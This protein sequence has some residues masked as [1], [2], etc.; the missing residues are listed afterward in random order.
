[1]GL[2]DIFKGK[3]PAEPQKA[4]PPLPPPI[5]AQQGP[6]AAVRWVESMGDPGD[7]PITTLSMVADPSDRPTWDALWKA[8]YA[9]PAWH[10]ITYKSQE[11]DSQPV[12]S[13]MGGLSH[14]LIYTSATRAATARAH[15]ANTI[16]GKVFEVL[17]LPVS[18]A[19]EYVCS[20]RKGGPVSVYFNQGTGGNG[21][22][23]SI[24]AVA[25]MLEYFTGALPAGCFARFIQS[26]NQ[27]QHPEIW[28]RLKMHLARLPRWYFL[29]DPD[30][31]DLPQLIETEGKQR[32]TVYS[33][34][35]EAMIAVAAMG[36]GIPGNVPAILELTP[37]EGAAMLSKVLQMSDGRVSEVILNFGSEGVALGISGVIEAVGEA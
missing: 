1:M 2:F 10:L 24:P 12:S 22:S 11:G 30:R 7:E 25:T 31:R 36:G 20:L 29:T 23:E 6:S 19:S 18:D 33:G 8:V 17:T 35:H 37:K 15:F 34:E 16:Q 27:M 9:L 26:G 28:R 13:S 21:F 32:T 14:A 4:P 5:S 3:N